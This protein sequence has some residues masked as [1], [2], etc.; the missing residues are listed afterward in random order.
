MRDMT[1]GLAGA[2]RGVRSAACGSQ[3]VV[4]GGA[5]RVRRALPQSQARGEEV[6]WGIVGLRDQRLTRPVWPPHSRLGG[7]ASSTILFCLFFFLQSGA[8]KGPIKSLHDVYQ[9]KRKKIPQ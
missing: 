4:C 5:G 2:L 1:A 8:R 9:E 3:L 6:N 7:E